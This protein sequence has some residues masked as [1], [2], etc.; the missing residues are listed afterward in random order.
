MRNYTNP[1]NISKYSNSKLLVHMT[2]PRS[3]NSVKFFT[4]DEDEWLIDKVIYKTRSGE[5]VLDEGIVAKD[6]D[7][8][9]KRFE[10][11]GYKKVI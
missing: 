8:F 11:E 1:G 4:D 7:H 10:E 5:I 9:I 2:K 3:H 6:F